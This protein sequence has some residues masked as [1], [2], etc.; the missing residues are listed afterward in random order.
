LPEPVTKTPSRDTGE[1]IVTEMEELLIEPVSPATPQSPTSLLL[2]SLDPDE[3]IFIVEDL[4]V[5]EEQPFVEILGEGGP[6]QDLVHPE[7][8]EVLPEP[9]EV[10]M[11]NRFAR[12]LILCLI[13]SKFIKK[14][15][16]LIFRTFLTVCFFGST[17][18]MLS[19]DLRVLKLRVC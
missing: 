9:M 3:D 19:I 8:R 2:R 6:P 15:R 12:F 16:S 11:N 13:L 10:Q 17:F 14:C 1:G 5:S 18:S 7:M 4:P